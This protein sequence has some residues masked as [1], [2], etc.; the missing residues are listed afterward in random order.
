M[1]AYRT[2]AKRA[3]TRVGS[4]AK[5]PSVSRDMAYLSW[6]CASLLPTTPQL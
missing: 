6:K 3:P 4:A 5:V 1:L 2:P